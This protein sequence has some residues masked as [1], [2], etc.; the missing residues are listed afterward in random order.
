[1]T[2]VFEGGGGG[3]SYSGA[4][5][6]GQAAQAAQQ[7]PTAPVLDL[8]FLGAGSEQQVIETYVISENVTNAQQANKKIQ[9]QAT[10]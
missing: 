5:T 2:L 8:G 3:S 10:L 9:D 7:T 6:A 1:M 4:G